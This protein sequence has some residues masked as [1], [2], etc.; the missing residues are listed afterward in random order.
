MPFVVYLRHH[1]CSRMVFDNSKLIFYDNA[2]FICDWSELYPD[3][4]E[5]IPHNALEVHW[6]GVVTSTF[7][8]SDH[9]G[10]KVIQH[11]HWTHQTLS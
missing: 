11:S 1:K 3:A 6:N 7:V 8:D 10:C 4:A 5:A 2:F 9:A